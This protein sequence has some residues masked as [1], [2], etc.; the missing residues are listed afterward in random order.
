MLLNVTQTAPDEICVPAPAV[1]FCPAAAHTVPLL[2][3]VAARDNSAQRSYAAAR[4]AIDWPGS[5]AGAGCGA[6]ARV[7]ACARVF[8]ACGPR[9]LVRDM[10]NASV[11]GDS[12]FTPHLGSF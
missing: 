3:A 4:E 12:R 8:P 11:L 2:P 9:G 1:S 7:W 10:C 6:A 5:G